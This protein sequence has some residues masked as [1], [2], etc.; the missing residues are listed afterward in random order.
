MIEGEQASEKQSR[1]WTKGKTTGKESGG[2]GVYGVKC[3]TQRQRWRINQ[4]QAEAPWPRQPRAADFWVNPKGETWERE[5]LAFPRM[6]NNISILEVMFYRKRADKK[7]KNRRGGMWKE[8]SGCKDTVRLAGH[9]AFGNGTSLA[10]LP[11]ARVTPHR[12][13]WGLINASPPSDYSLAVEKV[14][15]GRIQSQQK[16]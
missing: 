13:F 9:V 2:I 16:A 7:N 1:E 15:S 12:L 11:S 10:D 5:T 4:Q 6:C 8:I 14:I 3:E